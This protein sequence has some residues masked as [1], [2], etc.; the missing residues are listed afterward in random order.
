M[1][2]IPAYLARRLRPTR[3]FAEWCK[4]VG[5]KGGDNW[6]EP[7]VTI[8][9]CRHPGERKWPACSPSA[10][11]LTGT[12]PCMRVGHGVG[13]VALDLSG[14]DRVEEL[15]QSN[16]NCRSLGFETDY[17]VFLPHLTL[18]PGARVRVEPYVGVLEFGPEEVLLPKRYRHS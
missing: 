17:P 16:L 14:G 1:A 11:E 7:H 2:D 13:V 10:L 8:L 15:V 3:P 18:W 6:S 12:F 5:R 9:Y 4:R